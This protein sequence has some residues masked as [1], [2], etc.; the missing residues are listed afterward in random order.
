MRRRAARDER[1]RGESKASRT[2]I[3]AGGWGR[4]ILHR[5]VPLGS[6]AGVSRAQSGPERGGELRDPGVRLDS[7]LPRHPLAETLGLL[8]GAQLPLPSTDA[9]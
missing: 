1:R 8:Q 5:I 2:S 9:T 4:V 6:A 3:G 7:E